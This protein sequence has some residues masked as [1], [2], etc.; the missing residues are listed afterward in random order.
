MQL[1]IL[2]MCYADLALD[3]QFSATQKRNEDSS[4]NVAPEPSHENSSS[5]SSSSSSTCRLPSETTDYDGKDKQS[6]RN[7]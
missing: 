4:I 7:S 6:P 3:W 1:A 5:S 2:S